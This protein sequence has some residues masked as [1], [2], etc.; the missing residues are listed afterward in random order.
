MGGEDCED[1]FVLVRERRTVVL[2]ADEELAEALA[3][4]QDRHSQEGS[5]QELAAR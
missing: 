2:P 4:L 1:L 5:R 3:L